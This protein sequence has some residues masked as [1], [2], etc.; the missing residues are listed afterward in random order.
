[1]RQVGLV[2]Y[3]DDTDQKVFRR[4]LLGPD[5]DP[6]ELDKPFWLTHGTDPERQAVMK[7]V[8]ED[9]PEATAPF[10]GVP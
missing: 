7:K 8:P 9:S 6:S 10:S 5:D 1:M 3:A 2:Y 4:V